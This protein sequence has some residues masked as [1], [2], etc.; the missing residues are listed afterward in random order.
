MISEILKSASIK[1]GDRFTPKTIYRTFQGVVR[2]TGAVSATIRIEA[3][4]E[5]IEPRAWMLLG[6]ITLSGNDVVADG[7]SSLTSWE[8]VRANLTAISGTGTVVTVNM[9]V[10]NV[11]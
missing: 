2:G 8:Y 1:A 3:S 7:F 4:N 10:G 6:T 11:G 9:G 5:A